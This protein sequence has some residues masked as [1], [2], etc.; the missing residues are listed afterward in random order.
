MVLSGDPSTRTDTLRT[1]LGASY[2]QPADRRR[3][4]GL[5]SDFRISVGRGLLTVPAGLQLGRPFSADGPSGGQY[6]FRLPA[7]NTACTDPTLSAL[8]GVRDAWIPLPDTLRIGREWSDTLRAVTCRDRIVLRVTA[9]L[10]FRVQRAAA[11]SAG[12]VVVS[13][14]RSSKGHLAGAGDQFGEA[15]SIEGESEGTVVYAFDPAAGRLIHAEGKTSLSFTLTSRRRTQAA[16]QES[17]VSITW[18]P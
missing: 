14:V 18:L 2:V 7:E 9:V 15:V 10:R 16:R 1:V 11:D 12:R 4:D 5:L 13:I 8:Q 6:S 17:Q 3:V